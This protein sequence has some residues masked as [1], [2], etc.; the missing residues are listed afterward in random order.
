MEK[1]TMFMDRKTQYS[2]NKYITHFN[3]I[4]I[5]LPNGILHIPGYRFRK[6]QDPAG[7]EETED[8]IKY[9]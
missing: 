1:Y 6:I 9:P 8:G 4:P 2:E 7:T 3:A 5:K